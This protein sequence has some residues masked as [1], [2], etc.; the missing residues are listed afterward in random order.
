[1]KQ[2]EIIVLSGPSGSG[3]STYISK[4]PTARI[5]S[6]DSLRCMY[7]GYTEETVHKYYT[8]NIYQTEKE[9]TVI[10]DKIMSTAINSGESVIV[11]NTNLRASHINKWKVYNLP[12]K[13][14]LFD[15]DKKT[16]I[17]RDQQRTRSVGKE[18]IE[19]QFA[20]YKN[21][22]NGLRQNGYKSGRYMG[23][24]SLSWW[25]E[26]PKIYNQPNNNIDPR[27]IKNNR[28]NT[29]K[30]DLPWCIICD[31]DGTLSLMDGRSP[32]DGA[33][34]GT[35]KVNESVASVLAAY[36]ELQDHKIF[37]FSGR[38]S[39]NG[40]LEAT[41]KWLGDNHIDY[42]LLSMRKPGDTRKDTIV[43]QEMFDRHIKDQYRVGF[44]LDDRDMMIDHWR[45]MGLD[46][47]QVYYGSF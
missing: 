3:K 12:I 14:L 24:N 36:S 31:L 18:L 5:I 19:K 10:F 26:N 1:M 38:N 6:R 8:G 7:F 29:G 11:D 45:N 22:P 32:Y 46:C 44:V 21:L 2:Q 4:L 42:H 39:D 43:K 40:G 25:P 41:K 37:L 30:S 34:C 17:Q 9:I 16:C 13:V 47:F 20:E 33:A 23:F 28:Y 15:T 35:D 27:T